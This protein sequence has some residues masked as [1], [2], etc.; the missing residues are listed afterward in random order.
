MPIKY[1]EVMALRNVG[2]KYA[3]TDR[4]VMLYAANLDLMEQAGCFGRRRFHKR[5]ERVEE[6]SEKV[7]AWNLLRPAVRFH[8]S[9][10]LMGRKGMHN[11]R[12]LLFRLSHDL[13][14]L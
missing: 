14:Y 2:Q 13:P 3:W 12:T 7:L 4:E 11:Q 9:T 1:D 8:C 6:G 5:F 10:Q